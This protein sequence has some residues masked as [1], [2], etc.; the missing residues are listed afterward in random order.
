MKTLFNIG[1]TGVLMF[2]LAYVFIQGWDAQYEIDSKARDNKMHTMI[3]RG[4]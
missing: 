3:E 2:L 4:F 1:I